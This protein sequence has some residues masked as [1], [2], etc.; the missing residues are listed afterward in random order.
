MHKMEELFFL[1]ADCN[2]N[3]FKLLYMHGKEEEQEACGG[4]FIQ[5]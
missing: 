1:Y 4:A 3:C 2:F 5:Q